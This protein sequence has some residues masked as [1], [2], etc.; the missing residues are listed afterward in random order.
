MR[1]KPTYVYPTKDNDL[2]IPFTPDR[3]PIE[4]DWLPLISLIADANAAIARY[5]GRLE[6]IPDAEV[7][8]SPLM[9]QEA[10]LSS[11]IEGTMATLEEVLEFEADPEEP[12]ERYEDI[13][14]ILNYRRALTTAETNLGEAPMTLSLVQKMHFRLL[15]GVR[16]E[17]KRRGEFRKSQNWI[18]KPGS[19]QKEATYIPPNP[20]DVPSLLNNWINYYHSDERE[21]LVQLSIVHAQ[22]ELIHPFLDGNG[23]IGRLL[24]PLFLYEKKVLHRP[25]FYASAYLESTRD[26]YYARL[27]AISE[28]GD[29][30]G[31]IRYFLKALTEQARTN[32]RKTQHV[33]ALYEECKATVVDLTNSRYAIQ[34]LDTLFKAPIFSTPRFQLESGIPPASANRIL[35]CLNDGDL[36]DIGRQGR[37]RRPTVYIFRRLIDI[38]GSY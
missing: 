9:T 16:G 5:D 19:L 17:A 3:L 28:E 37:G 29:W 27:K 24:V 6:N 30:N 34:A 11:R 4:V 8:L 14:E 38:V 2:Q 22:F 10:V 33:M 13:Q 21:Y 25:M 12:T 26:E 32:S 1:C 7:L 15:Q 36:I 35:K 18:G 23:R 31:W 20:F